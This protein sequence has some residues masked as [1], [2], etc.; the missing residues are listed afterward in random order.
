MKYFKIGNIFVKSGIIYAI[1]C[2][3]VTIMPDE[4]RCECG[5]HDGFFGIDDSILLILLLICV[6]IVGV[7]FGR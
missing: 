7:G 1:E 5:C 3:E 6:F 4:R 2:K